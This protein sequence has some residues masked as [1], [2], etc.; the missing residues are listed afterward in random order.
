MLLTSTS[1]DPGD[2][3]R[4]TGWEIKPQG[5][6]KGDVCVPLPDD[7]RRDDGTLDAA[8]F[9]ARMGMALLSDPDHGVSVLGPA[10]SLTGRAL[11][12]AMAPDLELP[13]LDGQLFRLSSL[14]G[15]KVAII[16]WA[17]W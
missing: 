3:L 13:D 12:T 10:R 1:I 11:T 9:A 4:E 6:C 16:S 15:T 7:V 14:R 17:S 8:H 5:A 2:L